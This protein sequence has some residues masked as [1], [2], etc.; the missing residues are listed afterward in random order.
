M[1]QDVALSGWTLT[2]RAGEVETTHKFHRQMKLEPKGMVTV[3]SAD[4]AGAVHEPPTSLV[5]KGQKWFPAEKVNTSLLNN[6][7]EV[8]INL[9]RCNDCILWRNTTLFVLPYV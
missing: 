7:S 5:M 6:N 9:H 2:R 8:R 4:A 3:W 1:S